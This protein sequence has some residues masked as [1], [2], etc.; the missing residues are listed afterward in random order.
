M[1]N[2]IKKT[3]E[4]LKKHE[5]NVTSIINDKVFSVNQRLEKLTLDINN[6]LP[7]INKVGSK[8]MI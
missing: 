4:T 6:K 8:N 2:K 3:L 5:E 1:K 7:I